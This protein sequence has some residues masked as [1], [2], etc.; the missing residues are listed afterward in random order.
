MLSLKA[1]NVMCQI[2]RRSHLYLAIEGIFEKNIQRIE[3]DT[4]WL[5][6]KFIKPNPI[7]PSTCPAIT[8]MPHKFVV[9]VFTIT[10]NLFHPISTA[11]ISDFPKYFYSR[12][13]SEASNAKWQGSY[14]HILEWEVKLT[15]PLNAVENHQLWNL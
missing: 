7:L 1:G 15:S 4:V 6:Q 9:F 8:N 14:S 3:N 10:T 12:P 5:L 11:C 2:N 13:Y